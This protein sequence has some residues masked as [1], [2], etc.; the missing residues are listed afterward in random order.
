MQDNLLIKKEIEESELGFLTE[1]H[2]QYSHC[3]WQQNQYKLLW[4]TKIIFNFQILE[5]RK[6]L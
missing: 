3:K 2:I 5:L 4:N 6:L 1:H